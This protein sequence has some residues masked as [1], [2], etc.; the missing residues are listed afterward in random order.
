MTAETHSRP[1]PVEIRRISMDDA[2]P[3]GAVDIRWSDGSSARLPNELLR[4]NCPC[5]T[6]REE[7]GTLEHAKPLSPKKPRLLNVVKATLDES[8][9]LAEIWAV[10]NYAVGLRWGDGHDTGIYSFEHL[11]SLT[12]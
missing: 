10:G 2:P 3:H 8:L 9:A 6:C 5:A 4:R 11:R 7:Q 12:R 1:H